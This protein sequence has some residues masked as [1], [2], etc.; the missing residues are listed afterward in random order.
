MKKI[1]SLEK[2]DFLKIVLKVFCLF[3]N[4]FSAHWPPVAY[5]GDEC[6]RALLKKK[7]N[8]TFIDYVFNGNKQPALRRKN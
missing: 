3:K 7:L 8:N 2:F 1:F 5:A 6:A 4:K